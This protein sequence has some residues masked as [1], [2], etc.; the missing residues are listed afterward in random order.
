MSDLKRCPFCGSGRV[1]V[2]EHTFHNLPDN[3]GVKCFN[4]K[5]ESYQFFDSRKE[6]IETWN[7]R[8]EPSEQERW[9]NGND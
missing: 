1:N 3:F 7:K 5:A 9:L 8:Y 6:A 2:I 4:C